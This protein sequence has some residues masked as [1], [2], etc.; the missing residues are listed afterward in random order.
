MELGIPGLSQSSGNPRIARKSRFISENSCISKQSWI[1]LLL[2]DSMVF[3]HHSMAFFQHFSHLLLPFGIFLP[4]FHS[5][6]FLAAGRPPWHRW[7]QKKSRNSRW[8]NPGIVN[9]C[10]GWSRAEGSQEFF[11]PWKRGAEGKTS[12]KICSWRSLVL[13]KM[14][15]IPFFPA[16]PSTPTFPGHSR[17]FLSGENLKF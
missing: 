1:K 7:D 11:L 17:V 14:G 6:Q 15:K 5:Q 4:F 3:S 10:L 16:F 12:P 8:D 13:K 2:D 9:L